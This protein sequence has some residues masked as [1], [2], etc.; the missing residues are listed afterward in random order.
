[1]CPCRLTTVRKTL[2]ENI[3]SQLTLRRWDERVDLSSLSAFWLNL[4]VIDPPAVPISSL[5]P[6]ILVEGQSYR[7]AASCRSVARPPP[8]L[9]WDTD[10]NGQSV[11]RSSDNGAVSSYYSL[12]PLRSMNGKKLD[13][14]VWHPTMEAPRRLRNNLVVH[15]ECSSDLHRGFCTCITLHSVALQKDWIAPLVQNKWLWTIKKLD[16]LAGATFTPGPLF[17]PHAPRLNKSFVVLPP[18]S[19]T[20]R[21]FWVQRRLVHGSGERCPEVCGWRKPQ[22]EFYLDQVHYDPPPFLSVWYSCD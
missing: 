10:L 18:S 17:H 12:H 7:P 8:R 11:N 21:G 14:L 4:V 19:S 5:D 1:M 16:C 2:L 13:C 20:R 15:C 6:V 9:S 22:T 3:C